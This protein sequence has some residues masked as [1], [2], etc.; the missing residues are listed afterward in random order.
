[1]P[2]RLF[3]FVAGLSWLLLGLWCYLRLPVLATIGIVS[4]SAT[5]DIELRAV[6]G[7]MQIGFGAW[8]VAGAWSA[9]W[10]PAVLMTMVVIIGSTFLGRL[11]AALIAAEV[12]PY[13]GWA[14]L[15]EGSF[16]AL[17]LLCLWRLRKAATP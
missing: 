9:R 14:L 2:T 17:A 3:L 1:M 11:G 13:I 4:T 12:P 15:Y 7:G 6:Y 5:G 8:I 10:R 16:S